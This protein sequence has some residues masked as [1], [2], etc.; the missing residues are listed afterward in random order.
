[1]DLKSVVVALIEGRDSVLFKRLAGD[2]SN[3]SYWRAFLPD[4]STVVC[5]K[6]APEPLKSEEVVDGERPTT[7]PFLDVGR[8]LEAGGIPVPKVLHEDLDLGVLV[9]EDL[10][11]ADAMTP[12]Q[13]ALDRLH[14]VVETPFDLG[15]GRQ[16]SVRMSVG[17]ALYPRD[18]QDAEA[19]LRQADTA[20]YVAKTRK[21]D[22]AFWW[23]AQ[24]VTLQDAQ[25]D[26]QPLPTSGSV[27]AASVS[28]FREVVDRTGAMPRG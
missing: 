16:V 11:A 8:F 28:R 4:G 3:R 17:V 23:T 13:A 1:M 26:D 18:G 5:M 21:A 24:T 9:L 27:A 25:A 12:L 2:A 14:G 10:D 7:L 15:Q 6:L 22:H 20:M 19:L